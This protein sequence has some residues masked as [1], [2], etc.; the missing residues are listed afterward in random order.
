M[1]C[2]GHPVQ[3]A[4]K[5]S[6]LKQHNLLK[7]PKSSLCS[8]QYLQLQSYPSGETGYNG[9]TDL[10]VGQRVKIQ[11]QWGF[12]GEVSLDALQPPGTWWCTGVTTAQGDHG[13][14][15]Y[16]HSS[17]KR[18]SRWNAWQPSHTHTSACLLGAENSQ[19]RDNAG[20][21]CG[22]K[23]RVHVPTLSARPVL[24]QL[25][26]SFIVSN[27]DRETA[28]V[29]AVDGCASPEWHCTMV[30][31]VPTIS[32][33]DQLHV[34]AWPGE[35][36]NE[37]I[38]VRYCSVVSR[39]NVLFLHH[40]KNRR[41]KITQFV[42]PNVTC[43]TRRFEKLKRS[44]RQAFFFRSFL[45]FERNTANGTT[46]SRAFGIL[47]MCGS[48]CTQEQCASQHTNVWKENSGWIGL[49]TVQK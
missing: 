44:S 27:L 13:P 9:W 37:W 16:G 46:C 30:W 20:C 47:S 10:S 12:L 24:R 8:T 21:T 34:A 40:Q 35:F 17:R 6:S 43:D 39:G 38:R 2:L 3:V 25:L 28:N 29:A 23:F 49:K 15:W 19:G 36:M 33:G 45:S 11:E 22:T 4:Q 1:I 48:K 26:G 41:V 42:H 32:D 31:N 5:F 7:S 18:W 14:S